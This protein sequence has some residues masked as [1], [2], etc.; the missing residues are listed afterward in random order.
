ME[1][2]KI[3]IGIFAHNEEKNIARILEA[4]SSQVLDTVV[5]TEIIVV[6]SGSTDSTNAVVNQFSNINKKVNLIE[7]KQR[8]GKSAAINVYLA[9]RQPDTDICVISSADIIPE[10]NTIE[11]LTNPFHEQKIG[12]SGVRPIPVNARKGIMNMVVHTLW[13]LHH[14]ISLKQPK[15]GEMIAFRANL[16][17]SIPADAAVDEAAIEALV[18]KTGKQA[19][20]CPEAIVM[21]RGPDNLSDYLKQRRRIACGHYWL[22]AETGYRVATSSILG[23]LKIILLKYFPRHPLQFPVICYAIIL[24]G[25]ARFLGH[26]DFRN[27]SGNHVVWEMVSS[28]KQLEP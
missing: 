11:L 20:Y 6:S 1:K 9:S 16:V 26:R 5:I 25:I 27:N 12:M 4:L 28:T 7:Q 21:N 13:E 24:E 14:Y 8:E 3:S 2:L 19:V 10:Q 17:R 18:F 22:I 23:I 15:L